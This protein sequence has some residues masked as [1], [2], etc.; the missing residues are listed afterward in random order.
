MYLH[1]FPTKFFC[2]PSLNL[3]T[4]SLFSILVVVSDL[5]NFVKLSPPWEASS[6]A[7]IQE[8]PSI[9]WNPKVHYHVHKS[10]PLAPVLSQINPVHTIPCCLRSIL[11]LSTHSCLGLPNG[12]FPSSFPT[13]I[14]YAFRFA[15]VHATCHAHLI[16]LDLVI[17]IILGEECQLRS[18]SLCSFLQPRHLISFQSKCFP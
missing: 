7:A 14:L 18:S 2:L 5:T 12:L 15:L 10:P 1:S 11:I 6:C 3:S 13:N 8:L 4:L 9:L 17:L 16:L